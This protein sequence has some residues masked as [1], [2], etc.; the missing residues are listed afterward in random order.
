MIGLVSMSVRKLKGLNLVEDSLHLGLNR[1]VGMV[2]GCEFGCVLGG[3]GCAFVLVDLGAHHHL[4]YDGVGVV[5]AQF[6]NLSAG[7]HEFKVRFLE[8][9]LEIF[10]S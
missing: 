7:F 1:G 4:I 2:G 5:E 8:V 3:S 9:V 10:P 6:V